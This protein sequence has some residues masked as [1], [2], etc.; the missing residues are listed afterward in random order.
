MEQEDVKLSPDAL[1]YKDRGKMKWIGLMLSDHAEAL[2]RQSAAKHKIQIS[3]KPR[4][5]LKEISACLYRSYSNKKPLSIQLDVIKNGSYLKDI[6]GFVVGVKDDTIFIEQRDRMLKRILLKD[7]RHIDWL[8]AAD[9]F[10]KYTRQD[11]SN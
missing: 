9:W 7:I 4:Q 2:K 10:E 5:S 1:G 3:P 8:N 6:E 11:T